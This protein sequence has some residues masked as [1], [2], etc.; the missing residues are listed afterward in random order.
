MPPCA[1]GAPHATC[2][3]LKVN[4]R[5][6]QEHC[7]ALELRNKRAAA[8]GQQAPL[9]VRTGQP[10]QQPLQQPSPAQQP[11]PQQQPSFGQAAPGQLPLPP[12]GLAAVHAAHLAPMPPGA[13]VPTRDVVCLMTVHLRTLHATNRLEHVLQDIAVPAL[14]PTCT[15]NWLDL[16]L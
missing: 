2:D 15:A 12:L 3:L 9:Q 1:D 4:M 13:P 14:A 5:T 10:P 11:T 7:I 16:G 6:M 8:S